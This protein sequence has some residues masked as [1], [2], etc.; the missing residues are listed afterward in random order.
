MDD[1][2]SVEG[3]SN[4]CCKM[5]SMREGLSSGLTKGASAEQESATN[6]LLPSNLSSMFSQQLGSSSSLVLSSPMMDAKLMHP[7]IIIFLWK[8]LGSLM[9]VKRSLVRFFLT[10]ASS[11]CL[12]VTRSTGMSSSLFAYKRPLLMKGRLCPTILVT[13]PWSI[14]SKSLKKSIYKIKKFKCFL[15]WNFNEPAFEFFQSLWLF[16]LSLGRHIFS[17][18]R[19]VSFSLELQECSQ[20]QRRNCREK[21]KSGP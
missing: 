20:G 14:L 8:L 9:R 18:S 16:L 5:E 4:S 11:W 10:L 2:T 15:K 1:L 21:R 12:M 17:I 6:I 13:F 3:S 7:S 19:K